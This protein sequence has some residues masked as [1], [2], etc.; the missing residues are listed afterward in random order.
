MQRY[1]CDPHLAILI[2]YQLVTDRHAV[3]AGTMLA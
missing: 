3:T 1:V 2:Q